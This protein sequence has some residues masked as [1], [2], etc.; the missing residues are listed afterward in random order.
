MTKV[1]TKDAATKK[2]G[3][4]EIWCTLLTHTGITNKLFNVIPQEEKTIL[5]SS[6]AASVQSNQCGATYKPKLLHGTVKSS[7]SDISTS[8][9]DVPSRRPD[10][11]CIREKF[12]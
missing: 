11:T 2:S 7:V 3:N 10:P 12:P 8:L 4:W 5:V 1:I 6:F 9:L